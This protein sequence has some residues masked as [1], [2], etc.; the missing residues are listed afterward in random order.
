MKALGLVLA[1]LA[2][3]AHAELVEVDLNAPGDALV[4]RDT[5]SG[6]DWLEVEGVTTG[7]SYEDI[8][9]GAGGWLAAGWRYATQA[10]VCHLFTAH[11]DLPCNSGESPRNTAPTDA[12]D[13]LDRLG[14]TETVIIT[15]P[16][17]YLRLQA[18]YEDGTGGVAAGFALLEVGQ[19]LPPGFFWSTETFAV[20]DQFPYGTWGSFLVRA[21]PPQVPVL[22]PVG[23]AAVIALLLLKTRL[24]GGDR[25]HNRRRAA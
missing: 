19:T 18:I 4:T 8:Q 20:A 1:L 21:T 23:V 12:Y 2:L 15:W 22:P 10:E 11:A 5:D 3:P 7:L 14:V 16:V 13:I 17:Q 9:A 24:G 6:L 25:S